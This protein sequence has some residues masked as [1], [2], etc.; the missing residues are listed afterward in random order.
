MYSAVVELRNI[1]S[2]A[3]NNHHPS[4]CMT[5]IVFALTA[6]IYQ[7]HS[8]ILTREFKVLSLLCSALL[9]YILP[10]ISVSYF[11]FQCVILFFRG[12]SLWVCKTEGCSRL[13]HV[14]FRLH[15]CWRCWKNSWLP[16]NT[17]WFISRSCSDAGVTGSFLTPSFGK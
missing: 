16:E 5:D 9:I 6:H 1:G 15:S 8:Y 13:F 2:I 10:Y 17:V 7:V 14:S 4:L 12:D 11:C 3:R